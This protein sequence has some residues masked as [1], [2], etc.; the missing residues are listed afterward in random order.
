M[1]AAWG[2][3]KV[4]SGGGILSVVVIY[5]REICFEINKNPPSYHY[6]LVV[7]FGI[8]GR[9]APLLCQ[10]KICLAAS[11]RFRP[12]SWGH[13]MDAALFYT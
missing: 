5:R 13:F 7:G 9:G 12:L 4:E 3:R 6:Y 2:K 1:Q 11:R 8:C 10:R